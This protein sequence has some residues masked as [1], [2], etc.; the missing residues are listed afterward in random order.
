MPAAGDVREKSREGGWKRKERG[1]E[2]VMAVRVCPAGCGDVED[3]GGV[4]G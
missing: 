3:C 2:V 4:P 1:G